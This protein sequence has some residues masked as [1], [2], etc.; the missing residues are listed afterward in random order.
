[1]VMVV[2]VIV[3]TGDMAGLFPQVHHPMGTG[4][5]APFVPEEFQL[6]AFK[7]EFTQFSP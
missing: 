4:N 6:P 7:G 2:S 3:I 5:T 1:M